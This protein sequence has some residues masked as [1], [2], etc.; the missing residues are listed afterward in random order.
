MTLDPARAAARGSTMR[1]ERELERI[2]RTREESLARE[3]YP[4]AKAPALQGTETRKPESSCL[5][6]A[7]TS[8]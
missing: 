7:G 5:T 3:I 1:G 6:K 8:F 2:K 4:S